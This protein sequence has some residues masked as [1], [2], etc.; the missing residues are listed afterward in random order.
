[1][2]RR[3][4]SH[5][6]EQKRT[7]GERPAAAGPI[8]MPIACVR[9]FARLKE[10]ASAQSEPVDHRVKQSSLVAGSLIISRVARHS[11]VERERERHRIKERD[12]RESKVGASS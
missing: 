11:R 4:R 5:T 10:R 9:F 8:S 2:K 3:R 12:A 7:R 6:G 1:M